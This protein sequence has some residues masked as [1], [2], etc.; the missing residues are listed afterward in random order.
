MIWNRA[1]LLLGL[2]ILAFVQPISG[3]SHNNHPHH[4]HQH[5]HAH[6]SAVQ[7]T[8]GNDLQSGMT[9]YIV[10]AIREG[11]G[12]GVSVGRRESS[13]SSQ[14][15]T[16]HTPTVKQ[17]SYDRNMGNPVIFSP[18]SSS[19]HPELELKTTEEEETIT[20]RESMDLNVC[21][22]GIDNRVWQ[23]EE[24]REQSKGW[25]WSPSSR[26]SSLRYVTLK[27]KPGHP[28]ESTVRNWFRIERISEDS[29][30]YRITYCPNVCES[31]CHVVCGRVGI[32]KNNGERW[33]SVSEKREF[34]FV[35]VRANQSHDNR[36]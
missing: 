23:V 2:S 4:H 14:S 3:L 25:W 35:F 18:A 32:T 15:H 21:F 7:D 6:Q 10:S 13:S 36:E 19:G 30:V 22:S 29:P 11:G 17:S 12:G 16:T 1:F 24:G 8:E 9:Y 34:P 20:I 28:G 31:S 5:Q 33:L 26:N 27:G